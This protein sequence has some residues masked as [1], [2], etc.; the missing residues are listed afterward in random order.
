MQNCDPEA[1]AIIED[2]RE[3]FHDVSTGP[4]SLHQAAI[5]KYAD[6]RALS[7]ARSLDSDIH[8]S[9]ITE[10]AVEKCS[11]ALYGADSKSWRYLIPAFMIWTL[12]RFRTSDAFLI[13]QTIYTFDPSDN[14]S[15]LREWSLDR[16]RGLSSSQC[17]AVCRFL[18]YMAQNGDFVD[19]VV[20]NRA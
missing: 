8:W 19:D 15:S 9:Q 20:A 13:D 7:R 17:K 11:A 2:I 14:D 5:I 10:T 3:A 18:M 4:L 16:Y 6:E 12:D 1:D